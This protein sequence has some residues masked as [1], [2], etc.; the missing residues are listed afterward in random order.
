M[1][2]KRLQE[3]RNALDWT[4]A[5]VAAALKIPRELV[6]MWESG[7]RKPN[8]RQLEELSGLYRADIA[9]L[10]GRSD[11]KS[12]TE[13]KQL[14]YRGI[15]HDL[16]PVRAE[17][18]RWLRFLDDWAHLVCD[19]PDFK[20][21]QLPRELDQGPLFADGRQAAT[22]AKDVRDAFGLGHFALPDLFV[23]LDEQNILV[24]Q[25][26]LGSI[27]DGSKNISGVFYNHPKLGYCILVNSETSR[28]RQTF[29]LAHEFA[30]ALFHYGAPS[31]I[32]SRPGADSHYERFANSFASH[33][34]VP[35]S[36]LNELIDVM[37]WKERLKPTSVVL[38]AH[39]FRVS[40]AF[41]LLRL[42]R[43]GHITPQQRQHWQELSPNSLARRAGLEPGH[44]HSQSSADAY[45]KRYPSSVLRK[46]TELFEA[47]ELSDVQ[48][49]DLLDIDI[50][51]VR[52]EILAN[53]DK[54][55]APEQAEVAEFALFA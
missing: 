25:R 23:F 46:V 17:I 9:Y 8:L 2:H 4:Q 37:G 47:D 43:D 45:I 42:E 6:T 11:T 40:Y 34:L 31:W 54:A 20:K 39:Y 32:I 10:L 41:L 36:A 50:L 27:G 53:P 29:T 5:Q 33:F 3:C 14:L 44:F 51:T 35:S 18:E 1:N 7:A 28:G 26:M 52:Q 24:C 22:K 48:V 16:P 38:L 13:G 12:A 55:E 19:E 15:E 30:H 49:S 21:A